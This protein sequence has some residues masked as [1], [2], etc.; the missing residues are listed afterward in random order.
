MRKQTTIVVTGA[1]WEN[2]PSD[3]STKLRLKSS[4]CTSVQSDSSFWCP[5]EETLHPWLSKMHPVKILIRPCECAGWSESLLGAHVQRY[6]IWQ[7]SSHVVVPIRMSSVNCWQHGFRREMKKQNWYFLVEG[8][9]IHLA[10]LVHFSQERQLFLFT[11]CFSAHQ[12]PFEMGGVLTRKALLQGV[13]LK[14]KKENTPKGAN[15]LHLK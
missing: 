14:R 5:H 12:T 3:R 11:V 2:V 9:W 1:T 7:C 10:D 8:D 4:T 15:S 6:F 13:V